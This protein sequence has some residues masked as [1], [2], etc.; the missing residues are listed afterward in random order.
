MNRN[1]TP[2]SDNLDLLPRWPPTGNRF[3]RQCWIGPRPAAA[4]IAH[5]PPS[6]V[7]ARRKGTLARSRRHSHWARRPFA[8]PPAIRHSHLQYLAVTVHSVVVIIVSGPIITR[9]PLIATGPRGRGCR[10]PTVGIALRRGLVPAY[11]K[12]RVSIGGII[13]THIPPNGIRRH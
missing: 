5:C 10:I 3:R 7:C 2:D 12:I 8:P 4:D 1:S 6:A 9:L 13:D 11:V